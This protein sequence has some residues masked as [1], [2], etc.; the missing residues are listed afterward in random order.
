MNYSEP[1]VISYSEKELGD[2]IKAFAS[3]CDG[4][5]FCQTG[6]QYSQKCGASANYC[7]QA[8]SYTGTGPNPQPCGNGS[9]YVGPNS[10]S[11]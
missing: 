3:P 2:L 7:T 6:T 5:L 8:A 10:L 9:A 1:K 11:I 4:G